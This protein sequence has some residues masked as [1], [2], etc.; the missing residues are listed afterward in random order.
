MVCQYGSAASSTKVARN[1]LGTTIQILDLLGQ[2]IG[3]ASL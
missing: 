2:H 1:I 3:M